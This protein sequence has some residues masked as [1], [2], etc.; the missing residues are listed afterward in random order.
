MLCVLNR[1]NQCPYIV[2]TIWLLQS[3]FAE[4]YHS[5]YSKMRESLSSDG[6]LGA[7]VFNF[8]KLFPVKVN[9]SLLVEGIM[10]TQ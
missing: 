4:L 3:T 6:I 9:Q 10:I 8:N 2:C 1:R 5:I 7:T